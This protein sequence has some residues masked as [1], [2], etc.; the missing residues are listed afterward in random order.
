MDINLPAVIS[1]VGPIASAV[2]SLLTVPEVSEPLVNIDLHH[3][4]KVIILTTRDI[5]KAD[6]KL[7]ISYG[8]VKDYDNK[9]HLN[10]TLSDIQF[11]YL[12]VDLREGGDRLFY[13][14]SIIGCSDYHQVLYKWSWENDLGLQFESEFADFPVVQASKVAF[15]RLLC[16]RPIT[17]P[18]ACLSFLGGALKCMQG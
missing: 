9:V 16:A 2:S 11:D 8:I 1:S 12:I 4:K 10:L 5:A 15:D 3:V 7:L 14:K 17:A 18:S 6:R 13:Q